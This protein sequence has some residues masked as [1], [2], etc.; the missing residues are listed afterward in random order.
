MG[1]LI[2]IPPSLV[3]DKIFRMSRPRRTE[4]EKR[5]EEQLERVRQTFGTKRQ[6]K[7]KK[8]LPHWCVY[9][10]WFLVVA[11]AGTSAFMVFSYR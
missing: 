1:S 3:I 8:S 6:A 7:K 10:G 11:A 4:A 2:V 5:A 9:I